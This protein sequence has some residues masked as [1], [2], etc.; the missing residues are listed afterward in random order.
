MRRRTFSITLALILCLTLMPM[1]TF[2]AE[3]NCK[4]VSAGGWHTMAI[5]TDG[6]LWA[7]GFNRWG[8]LGNGKT[9]EEA[10]SSP[11][12]IMDNVV[13]ISAGN[14]RTMAIKTDGTLWAW[15]G[16][17]YGGLGDGTKDNNSPAPV[18]IM[19]NAASVS[20]GY[21][22][23][24]AI[25]T[26]GTLW[27]WGGNEYGQLG[28]GTDKERPFP[29]K[30]MD[31][32]ASVAVGA[33]HTMAIKTDG[34]L[35]AWGRNLDGRLGDGT[36]EDRPSPVKIMDNVTS[37]AVGSDHTMAIKT[38]GTLWAWGYNA[39]GEL[40]DG[41]RENRP[42]P[43]KIMNTVASVSAGAGRT[44]AIMT[45]GTLWAWGCSYL[46]WRN[47]DDDLSPVKIMDNASSVSVGTFHIM[48][49]K[50]DGTLWAWGGNEYGQLGD[51]TKENRLSPVKI[52]GTA[53]SGFANSDGKPSSW[54]E[55]QVTTAIDAELVPHA[56]QSNYIQATTRAEF[57]ALSVALYEKFTGKKIAD[58]NT[59]DD[60]KDPN[61][62]KAAA[63]GV[64]SG[65]GNNKFD[66]GTK[67]TREQA[68]TMLSRLADAVGKPL[69]K[70][71][72]SF[73]DNGELSSWAAES[74]GQIQAAGIMDGVGDNTFAPRAPYT[75]EQ[76]IITILRL[77]NAVK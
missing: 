37:I 61:V 17:T 39:Y 60:T 51:G 36:E 50:A 21:Y 64:V 77:F 31:G 13:Y 74:V 44:A 46:G 15:G 7:W 49:I 53:A 62:E 71:A 19:N 35:W 65:V 25:K 73:A 67:L 28:D 10:S 9:L 11:M 42:F 68:A 66:P 72:A 16:N 55:A 1:T 24:M 30:I 26:D 40:G 43:V 70:Q 52:M 58:R 48:A 76:S 38:D 27:A 5:K 54:A 18:K 29:V 23:A 57:C 8:Q 34:T 69:L 41:T 4:T 45:D 12:K 3:S 20:A 56:L 22:H 32:I 59:F 47:G 6:A 2:A 75:R 63:I 14:S 33:S